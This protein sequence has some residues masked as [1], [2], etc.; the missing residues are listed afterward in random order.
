MTCYENFGEKP[1]FKKNPSFAKLYENIRTRD[2]GNPAERYT[3][4]PLGA[5]NREG[6]SRPG[7][8]LVGPGVPG[9]R[10]VLR[11]S[12]FLEFHQNVFGEISAKKHTWQ[13]TRNNIAYETPLPDLGAHPG[14]PLFQNSQNPPIIF[15][16]HSF[17]GKKG[18]PPCENGRAAEQP[19]PETTGETTP[20]HLTNTSGNHSTDHQHQKI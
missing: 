15:I 9:P 11:N 6:R 17:S 14:G 4:S 5:F 7:Q 8:P 16:V 2:R 20:G 1:I 10:K 18:R 3:T 13:P 19:A 12:L